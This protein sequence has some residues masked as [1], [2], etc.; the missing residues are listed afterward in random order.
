MIKIFDLL[1]DTP[2]ECNS[3]FRIFISWMALHF[4]YTSMS[5]MSLGIT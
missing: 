2:K 1:H 4:S 3:I 5:S